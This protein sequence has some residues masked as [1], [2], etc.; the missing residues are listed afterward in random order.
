MKYLIISMAV[1]AVVTYIIRA[2]PLSVFKKEITS[3]KVK[4]FLAYIPYAVL[5]AMTFPAILSS[6]GSR[7]SAIG[8]LLAAI[9]IAYIGGGLLTTAIGASVMVF[10]IEMFI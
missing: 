5:S 1:M 4:A 2:L 9:I 10:I 8:G 7:I 6:T 3:K